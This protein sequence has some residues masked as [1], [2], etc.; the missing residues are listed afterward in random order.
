MSFGG[1]NRNYDN[2]PRRSFTPRPMIK[3]EWK[4]SE[5]GAIITEMPFQPD[6]ERP[7]FCRE[8]WRKKRAERPSRF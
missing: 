2:G 8:C 6:P 1:D 7:I 5:C 4:C 3:G